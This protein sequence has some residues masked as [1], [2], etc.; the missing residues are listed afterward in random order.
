MSETQ[1]G[2]AGKTEIKSGIP[3]SQ[4]L[5]EVTVNLSACG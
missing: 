2:W 4:L 1:K 5:G 3:A